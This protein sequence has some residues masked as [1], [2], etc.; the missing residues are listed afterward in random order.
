MVSREATTPKATAA[1]KMMYSGDIRALSKI[2]VR[3]RDPAGHE[4]A[5]SM[6]L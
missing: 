1:V 3:I 4:P 5:W 6:N 2:P